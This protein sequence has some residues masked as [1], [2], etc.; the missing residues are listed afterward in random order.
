MNDPEV[1]RDVVQR[2]CSV[3]FLFD[4]ECFLLHHIPCHQGRKVYVTERMGKK[5]N[6]IICLL[7]TNFLGIVQ[8]IFISSELV[9]V[10]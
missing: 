4:L 3:S 5:E 10:P 8:W 2:Y 9:Q 7:V 1:V 6:S